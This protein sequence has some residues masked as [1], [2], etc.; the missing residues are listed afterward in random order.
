MSSRGRQLVGKVEEALVVM[1]VVGMEMGAVR[2]VVVA[3]VD[4]VSWL[5]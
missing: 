1:V 4:M 2:V 3:E 5:R